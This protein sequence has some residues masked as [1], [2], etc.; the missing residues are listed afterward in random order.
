MRFVDGSVGSGTTF[1]NKLVDGNDPLE[2]GL[3]ALHC[4]PDTSKGGRGKKDGLREYA[5]D[6]GSGE[7]EIRR[8]RDAAEVYVKFVSQNN[9]KEN[10]SDIG[11]VSIEEVLLDK[12]NYL[13]AIHAAPTESW[14]ALCEY[15]LSAQD[16]TVTKISGKAKEL[17]F[18]NERL[19]DPD[20]NRTL[21]LAE[22]HAAPNW[23]WSALVKQMVESGWTVQVTRDKVGAFKEVADPPVW[24]DSGRIAEALVSGQMKIAEVARLS[25][26]ARIGVYGGL[27]ADFLCDENFF[28]E[29]HFYLSDRCGDMDEGK[30]WIAGVGGVGR[31]GMEGM[32]GI[33]LIR[34]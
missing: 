23:L 18:I 15:L 4:V 2:Y 21:H 28:C 19:L 31:W 34:N 20:T 13:A 17:A 33:N 22:I 10:P 7:S 5:N 3:H 26:R 14:P 11:G 8:L 30:A 6:I 16:V 29:S 25:G 24:A 1:V 27:N 32:V 9:S 12:H